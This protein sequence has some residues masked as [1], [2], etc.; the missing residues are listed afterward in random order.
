MEHKN[1]NY[2]S[3]T[4]FQCLCGTPSKA[5]TMLILASNR[6]GVITSPIPAGPEFGYAD[7][8]IFDV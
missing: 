4:L 3:W 8:G 7:L 2:H 6:D 1:R 5:R